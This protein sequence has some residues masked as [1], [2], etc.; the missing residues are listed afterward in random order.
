MGSGE[1]P[2]CND[3]HLQEIDE[4]PPNSPLLVDNDKVYYTPLVT[5]Q[6]LLVPQL[7]HPAHNEYGDRF[8]CQACHAQWT[9]NDSPTHLLRIDHD[10]FD[11]FYKL[12]YLCAW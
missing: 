5:A 10:D 4:I 3:C 11:Y 9:F 6:R 2:S 7:Q 8:S 12:T 1:N